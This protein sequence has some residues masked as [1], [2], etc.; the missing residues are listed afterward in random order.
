MSTADNA[1]EGFRP[2]TGNV[3][4]TG[5]YYLSAGKGEPVVLLHGWGGFKE[6]WWGTM[7]ALSP[8]HH[9]IAFDWPGHGSS[10][11]LE[12]S[13]P[14]LD[15]LAD[16]AITSC[17]ALGLGRVTLVGHS[18]GGNVAARVALTRPDLIARLAL[19]DAV[20]NPEHLPA[21]CWLLAHPR[22]G[23][24]ALRFGRLIS[25]PLSKLGSRIPH[26]HGGGFLRPLARRQS[27]VAQVEVSV[28]FAFLAALREGSL[29]ERLS[30]ITQPT[31]ILAGERDPLVRPHQACDLARQI[32]HA[33]LCLLRRAYHCPMDEQPTAFHQALIDFLQVH[34]FES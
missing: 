4:Q 5:L 1:S 13:L 14:V 20:V 18:L 31:L 6:M 23:E 33:Q 17:A 27:R 12:A 7:Q 10:V 22:I 21:R 15:A 24:R 25:W 19:I 32:P 16:L 3:A 28:L 11:P 30:D 8:S 26:E 34:T 29:A 2:H 9:V